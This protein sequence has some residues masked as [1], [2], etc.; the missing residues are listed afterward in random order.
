MN[1]PRALAGDGDTFR[2]ERTGVP[3]PVRGSCAHLTV[4]GAI[5]GA[6]VSR[7]TRLT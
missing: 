2:V 3:R 4:A 1:V 5:N 7:E 6:L